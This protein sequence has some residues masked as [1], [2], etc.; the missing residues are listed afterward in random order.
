MDPRKDVCSA[1]ACY[2]LT[3][4]PSGTA[5]E[6]L[7]VLYSDSNQSFARCHKTAIV[8]SRAIHTAIC[9]LDCCALCVAYAWTRIRIGIK[10]M[11][12]VV[13]LGR[14]V[15]SGVGGM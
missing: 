3:R 4:R 5:C 10:A 8:L 15:G 7:Y 13:M 9:G 6:R 1:A 14:G 11:V 12:E 2:Q